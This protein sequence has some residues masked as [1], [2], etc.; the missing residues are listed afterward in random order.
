MSIIAHCRLQWNDNPGR[1]AE[2][3]GLKEIYFCISYDI[4]VPLFSLNAEKASPEGAD[5]VCFR[6]YEG[7]CTTSVTK[8]G[9]LDFL[10]PC[11]GEV[12]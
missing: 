7:F 8:L 10:N 2:L 3:I 12:I 9:A 4:W 5:E 1:E 6:N 11:I